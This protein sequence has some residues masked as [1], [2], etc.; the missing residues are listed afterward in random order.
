MSSKYGKIN[1]WE[2]KEKKINLQIAVR[3]KLRH[4]VMGIGDSDLLAEEL[5]SAF[6]GDI[7]IP[8]FIAAKF[9]IAKYDHP[10]CP[11]CSLS[12]VEAREKRGIS[13]K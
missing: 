7:C 3:K 9:T 4:V 5:K 8:M 2:H 11:V 13:C 6:Y 12:Y 1:K 10:M